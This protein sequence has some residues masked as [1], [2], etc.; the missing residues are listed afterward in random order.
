M[1]LNYN[2]NF[3]NMQ[4]LSTVSASVF[5]VSN[6]TPESYRSVSPSSSVYGAKE[7]T[8]VFPRGPDVFTWAVTQQ[9]THDHDYCKPETLPTTTLIERGTVSM[10]GVPW[11]VGRLSLGSN[12]MDLVK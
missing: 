8:F 5:K 11:W 6:C 10:K 2:Y 12:A 7:G 4:E 3:Y 9:V 1:Y